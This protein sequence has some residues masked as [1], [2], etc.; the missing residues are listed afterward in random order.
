[1]N[2]TSKNTASKAARV[3]LAVALGAT[4][5]PVAATGAQAKSSDIIRTASCGSAFTKLKLGMENG[6]IEAEY[7]LDQNR[8]GRT[9]TVR[10]YQNGSLKSTTTRTTAAPSG[11]FSVNRLLTNTRGTDRITVKATRGMATCTITASI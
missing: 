8:S 6:R 3:G 2:V 7:E 5:V 10:F 1:M 9:W 11:S 4:L